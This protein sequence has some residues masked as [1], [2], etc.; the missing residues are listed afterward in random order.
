[1]N[2]GDRTIAVFREA[3]AAALAALALHDDVAAAVFP[4][5]IDVRLRAAVGVGEAVLR[6]R[7][8]QRGGRRPGRRAP[9]GGRA[10]ARPSRSEA[11]A[12]LLLGLVGRDV[13]IVPLP[14]R[15]RR[16]R[17]RGPVR[18]SPTGPVAVSAPVT[19]ACRRSTLG[20][21][22]GRGDRCTWPPPSVDQAAS[23]PDRRP[24]RGRPA[25][26]RADAFVDAIQHPASLV[27][28]LG[29]GLAA[30][31]LLVLAPELGGKR[32]AVAVLVLAVAGWA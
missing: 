1:M 29:A 26:P 6:R 4:P 7:R 8:L 16:P 9:R 13:S 5:D 21:P 32:L 19:P 18:S 11:T 30:I 22:L 20:R 23:V 15:A 17:G 28:V 24:V 3:S 10:R 12:E 31:C 14:G 25:R 27:A 2:E